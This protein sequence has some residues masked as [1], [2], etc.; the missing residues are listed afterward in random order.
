MKVKSYSPMLEGEPVRE[1]H[2]TT[3][4]S[5]SSYGQ[6]VLI[7]EGVGPMGQMDLTLASYRIVKATAKERKELQQ[8][9]Y[10]ILA[11]GAK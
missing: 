6:P 3:E 8:A 4:S 5:S 1:A 9:G 2:L 10:S 7:V 11:G